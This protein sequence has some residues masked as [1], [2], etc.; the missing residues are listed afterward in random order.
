MT[1]RET[2]PAGAPCWTDLWTSDVEGA[3]R[4]YADL[5]GWGAQE[6]DPSHGGYWMFT[7]GGTSV[8]GGMGPMGDGPDPSNSWT[9]YFA[10][11]DIAKSTEVAG[12]LGAHVAVPAMPVDELGTQAVLEDPTGAH[13]GFWQPGTFPGFTVLEE[14]G[15][16]SW[17]ELHVRDHATAVAFYS[18]VLGA[19]VIPVSDTDQ[20]RYSLVRPAGAAQEVAGIMQDAGLLAPEETARWVVYWE[21]EDV[22]ATLRRVEELGGTAHVGPD[23]TP[24]G[25]L[26]SASDPYG[27]RFNLRRSPR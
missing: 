20:F 18:E 9:P 27:A 16:P 1:I 13:L 21:V 8:A 7:L 11:D 23:D 10:T 19:E 26:G 22:A 17:F 12:N 5:L 3:R 14:P 25:V 4:F 15:A 24:Y 2:A 6:P